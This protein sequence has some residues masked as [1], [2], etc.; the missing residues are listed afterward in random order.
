MAQSINRQILAGYAG[1]DPEIRTL[2]NGARTASFSIATSE[3]WV[4]KNTGERKEKT[5]WHRVVILGNERLVDVA[6][7]YIRKGSRV[8]IEGKTQT[9]SYDKDGQK[10]Q[11]TEVVLGPFNGEIMLMDRAGDSGRDDGQYAPPTQRS[12]HS[13]QPTQNRETGQRHAP[14][15][16]GYGGQPGGRQASGHQQPQRQPAMA[17]AGWNN[18]D[19]DTIPF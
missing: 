17:G 19:L 8:Y 14:Q 3:S 18:D 13:Q 9:R 10:L 15:N 12:Q 5:E 11:I 16:S 1:K 2:Q 7:K 4:D 6:E